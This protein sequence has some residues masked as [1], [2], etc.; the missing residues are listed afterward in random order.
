MGSLNRFVRA[1]RNRN[2]LI[3]VAGNCF[4]LT[5]LWMQRI[6]IGWLTWEL[7]GSAT[8]LGIIAFAELAPTLVIGP[9]AGAMA[10]RLDRLQLAKRTQLLVVV[11]T[12]CLALVTLSGML[13][14]WLLLALTVIQGVIFSFWQP[15]RL[16]LVTSLVSSSELSS[17]IAINSII[18]NSARF[19]GPAL[20]GLVLVV[21]SPGWAFLINAVTSLIFLYALLFIKLNAP[22]AAGRSERKSVFPILVTAT[23]TQRDIWESDHCW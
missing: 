21:S 16:A 23:G 6:A 9:F 4:N 22:T 8:W 1:L 15:V 20:A 3:Y 7:T 2:F 13:N 18:F 12:T 17:A 10:D 11:Q 19:I 5:G 14:I